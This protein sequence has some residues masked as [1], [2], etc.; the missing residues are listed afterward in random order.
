[1]ARAPVRRGSEPPP[2]RTAAAAALEKLGG[3]LTLDEAQCLLRPHLRGGERR[4]TVDDIQKAASEHFGLKQADL[5][6][7][8]RTRAVDVVGDVE[9]VGPDRRHAESLRGSLA[10]T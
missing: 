5:I 7:E 9:A 10:R 3:R 4:V 1:M 6:S 2:V 8:R